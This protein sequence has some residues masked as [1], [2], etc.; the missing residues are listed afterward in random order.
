MF[1]FLEFLNKTKILFESNGIENPQFEAKLLLALFYKIKITKIFEYNEKIITCEDEEKLNDIIKIRLTHKPFSK[2]FNSKTFWDFDFFVNEDVLDPRFDTEVLI[3]EMIKTY[4]LKEKLKILDL[5]TGS[6]CII[7]T[8]L[9]I[10][11]NMQGT[12]V[13]I[14]E[15]ALRVACKNA[16]NLE[17]GDR[18]EFIKSDWNNDVNEKFDII[19]SNPPYIPT[20]TIKALSETVQKFDPILALDGGNE[21]LD[22]YEFLSRNLHKNCKNTTKIFLEIGRGQK[23]DVI[24]IF[25]KNNFKFIKSINDYAGICRILIFSQKI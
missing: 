21:G 4:E 1:T 10:F 16:Y 17:V 3:E 24:E 13:D 20:K 5:G 2:I 18:C 15:N 7:I 23:N 9:K 11:I 22:C 14:S 12:A 6:G 19:V 8:L 25:E